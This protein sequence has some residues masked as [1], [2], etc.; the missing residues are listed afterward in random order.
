MMHII[1]IAIRF[2]GAE[3]EIRVQPDPQETVEEFKK[4]MPTAH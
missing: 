4:I 2:S 1:L 3:K